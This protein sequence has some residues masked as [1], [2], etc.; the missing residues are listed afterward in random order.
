LGQVFGSDRFDDLDEAFSFFLKVTTCSNDGIKLQCKGC[1]VV[2]GEIG[3][4]VL[5]WLL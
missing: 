5:K 4:E 3:F 2:R 1:L